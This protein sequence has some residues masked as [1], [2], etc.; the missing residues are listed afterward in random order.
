MLS[1]Y[2]SHVLTVNILETLHSCMFFDDEIQ[3][4]MFFLTIHD[5]MLHALEK[6]GGDQHKGWVVR[7][8]YS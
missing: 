2:H 8:H 1:F 6:H 3:T 4:S 7:K 5:A